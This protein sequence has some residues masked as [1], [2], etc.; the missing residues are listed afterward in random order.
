[1]LHAFIEQIE[2]TP[3][4]RSG[5]ML[6]IKWRDQT[7]DEAT[8]IRQS[9]GARDWLMS[10]VQEL[11]A[12]LDN[13]ASQV[14]IAAAFPDR[15]WEAIR[16]RIWKVRGGGAVDYID[17]K[18]MRDREKYADFVT[19]INDGT[20]RIAGSGDRWNTDDEKRLLDLFDAGATQVGIAEAFPARRWWRIRAKLAKMRGTG[21]K[22][23]AVGVIQRNKTI[24]DHWKRAGQSSDG[25]EVD[26]DTDYDESTVT[27]QS[28]TNRSD[29]RGGSRAH[30][31]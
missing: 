13:D 1:V 2:A 10:E 21:L 26:E 3:F 25:E 7:T 19:R 9:G 20:D 18:P 24:H 31:R 5:L 30:E 15:T 17:P 12:L 22:I 14:E 16:H 4:D 8:L 6:Q 27:V 29:C 28:T 23:P 11:L